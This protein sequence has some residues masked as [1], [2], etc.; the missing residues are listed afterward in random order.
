MGEASWVRLG[1]GESEGQRVCMRS[2]KCVAG[3]AG[4]TGR[5][6]L[7]HALIALSM[8][9]PPDSQIFFPAVYDIKY[10]MKFC[11]NLHGGLNKLAETL[12][13]ARIGPQHQVRARG[14][15]LGRA[16]LYA[17]RWQAGRCGSSFPWGAALAIQLPTLPH[18]HP[19]HRPS[20]PD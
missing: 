20:A 14:W 19:P 18:T 15:G 10:L 5:C 8:L 13:V 17:G 4:S 3:S 7:A 6:T 1:Q 9:C 12:D 2:S 11:D 16:G